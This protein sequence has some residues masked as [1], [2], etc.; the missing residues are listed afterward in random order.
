MIYSPLVGTLFFPIL[1][2]SHLE[3]PHSGIVFLRGKY[4]LIARRN[5][6]KSKYSIQSAVF[7]S[8]CTYLQMLYYYICVM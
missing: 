1:L 5:L 4:L 6:F 2:I 7:I 3:R 8:I